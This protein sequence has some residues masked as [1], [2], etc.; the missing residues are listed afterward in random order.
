MSALTKITEYS[1]PITV[2]LFALVLVL[3]GYFGLHYERASHVEYYTAEDKTLDE[4]ED[5]SVLDAPNQIEDAVRVEK[6]DAYEL[7]IRL[8]NEQIPQ[9][10]SMR[11]AAQ[12][13]ELHFVREAATAYAQY[14][15]DKAYTWHPYQLSIGYEHYT[16]DTYTFFVLNEYYYTGGAN[17]TQV[18]YS[19][20]YAGS[21]EVS[22]R[23][24]IKPAIQQT[25][26][27][28]VK[29]DLYAQNGIT[30]SDNHIFGDAIAE[31]TFN[32]LEYFYLTDT[33][34]VLLFDEYD[35]A[36]GALGAVRVRIPRSA[37][38]L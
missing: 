28:L 13:H 35:V 33:E 17:G 1:R 19:F 12:E 5:E 27:Q 32:D 20:G 16:T 25:V 14:Q 26:L 10:A 6:T 37:L 15:A 3:A 38:S 9:S 23:D 22:L 30:A 4:N 24:I 29:A 31:L 34:L 8:P 36:P 7:E 2:L 18:A 21:T 11:S